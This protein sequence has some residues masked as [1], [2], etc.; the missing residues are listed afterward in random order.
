MQLYFQNPQMQWGCKTE[1]KSP[2]KYKSK[3]YLYLASG[4]IGI[5]SQAERQAAML[6]GYRAIDGRP[7]AG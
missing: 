5:G 4:Y 3:W 6:Q 1:S 7:L 2:F